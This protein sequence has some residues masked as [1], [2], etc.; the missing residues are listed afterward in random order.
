MGN[1]FGS[2]F[3]RLSALGGKEERRLLML[4]LDAAGK[5]TAL[6]KLKI[7]EE[8]ATVPTIGFNTEV[9][10]YK[11]VSFT[12]W[13]VGGQDKI[14]TLWRHYFRG[15]DALMWIVDSTDEERMELAREELHKLLADP[16]LADAKLL[17][18]AN[19]QDMPHALTPS[20]VAER[21][22][23]YSLP[24]SREWYI[25]GASAKRGDGLYE[26]LD[27]ICGALKKKASRS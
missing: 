11:N 17:V 26:G 8:V 18:F 14:R 6:M 2:I 25:Q 4:G 9:I 19:K 7:G 20:Q 22:A 10:E 27:W 24:R 3:E 16:E 1:I 23:L 5:T 15:T 12:A 21:M 13:D